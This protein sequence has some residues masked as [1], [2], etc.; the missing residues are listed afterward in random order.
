[1]MNYS[2]AGASLCPGEQSN[3][4]GMPLLRN[5]ELFRGRGIPM[6]GY[7]T[8]MGMPLLRKTNNP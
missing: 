7:S 1:M 5:D 2:V 8:G 6:P 3:G 4:I